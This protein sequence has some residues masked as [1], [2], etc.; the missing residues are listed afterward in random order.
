MLVEMSVKSS[1][2]PMWSSEDRRQITGRARNL[3]PL[4]D[5]A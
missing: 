1:E 4:A 2:M 3:G 5:P